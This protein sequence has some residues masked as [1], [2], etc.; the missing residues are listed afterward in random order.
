M[1]SAR[2]QRQPPRVLFTL[3]Q[4]QVHETADEGEGEGHPRQDEGVAVAALLGQGVQ[5]Q[6][7]LVKVFTPVC[8]YGSCNHDT[9][10]CREQANKQITDHV[11]AGSTDPR[12]PQ[13]ERKTRLSSDYWRVFV[14]VHGKDHN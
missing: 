2:Q 9:Q 8:I 14:L 4:D 6:V 3:P 7:I 13:P 11:T 5:S 1:D 10:A 12:G